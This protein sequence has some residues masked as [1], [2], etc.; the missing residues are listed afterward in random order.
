MPTSTG[1]WS[2]LS[3]ATSFFR[4]MVE[5]QF[6]STLPITTTALKGEHKESKNVLTWTTLTEQNNKGFEIQR[7]ADGSNFSSIGFVMSKAINGNSTTN[8]DYQ[9]E[10]I[11]PFASNGYYRVKQI[12]KDCKL[13]YSN[14]VLLKGLKRGDVTLSIYPNPVKSNLNM[15]ITAPANNKATLTIIDA[16]G[17]TI[18]QKIEQLLSGDNTVS[19]NVIGLSSG[20]YTIKAVYAEGQTVVKKFMKQ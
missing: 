9:F 14:A 4:L 17:R 8:I 20:S 11:K 19:L 18:M 16:A 7:S 3:S 1:T 2:D 5:A 10:D 12:D 13:M 15:V 6:V